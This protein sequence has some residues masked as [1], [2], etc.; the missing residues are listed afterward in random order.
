MTRCCAIQTVTCICL[1][2]FP[3]SVD[4]IDLKLAALFSRHKPRDRA[5]HAYLGCMSFSTAATPLTGARKLRGPPHRRVAAGRSSC[6]SLDRGLCPTVVTQ[7]RTSSQNRAV[8]EMTLATATSA[9]ESRFDPFLYAA[10]RDDPDAAPLTVLSVLA[11]LGIDPWEEAARLAQL[12]G[13]AAA[14]AL[15]GLISALPRGSA[16]PPDSRTIAARLVT[17]LPPRSERGIAAQRVPSGAPRV[18]RIPNRA[19][20]VARAALCLIIVALL[21]ISQWVAVSHL[22]S[23]PAKTP[24]AAPPTVLPAPAARPDAPP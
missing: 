17:L 15:A 9:L 5:A 11:R 10:V 2:N 4:R 6:A 3:L 16:T 21:L 7:R 20:I 22:A 8:I 23:L 14:R 24:L 12:P 19:T 13:E 18:I 1:Q